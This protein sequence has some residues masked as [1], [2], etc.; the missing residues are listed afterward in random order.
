M[1]ALLIQGND[2][3][4]RAEARPEARLAENLSRHMRL[5]HETMPYL[6]WS[7][8]LSAAA[9]LL[10]VVPFPDGQS[11]GGELRERRARA[12]PRPL[13]RARDPR[14][15]EGRHRSRRRAAPGPRP[16]SIR[17]GPAGRSPTPRRSGPRSALLGVVGAAVL[18]DFLTSFLRAFDYP[19]GRL[20]LVD[21]QLQ[22]LAAYDGRNLAG[23]DLLHVA[24]VLPAEL[25]ALEPAQLLAP[26]AGV[27]RA[28]R[29][30]RAHPAG[31]RRRP[32]R[33]ST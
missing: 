29:R 16:T 26:G 5:S 27:P 25:R 6:R 3:A 24:D 9:D 19:G 32:G 31:R 17:P 2:F 14:P 15:G 21:D 23:L 8:Y 13:R 1:A 7:Y 30:P 10:S 18:L 20:W 22:V 12:D 28:R 4:G 11:F 33:C